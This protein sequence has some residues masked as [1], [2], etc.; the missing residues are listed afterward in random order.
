VRLPFESASMKSRALLALA[1]LTLGTDVASAAPRQRPAPGPLPSSVV[2]FVD[3]DDDDDDGVPDRDQAAAARSSAEVQWLGVE[4]GAKYG[5]RAIRGKGVR[6]LS[7]GGAL[8]EGSPPRDL[9]ARFGLLGVE[10]GAARLELT[11]GTLDA[12][13]YEMMAFDGDGAR[14]DLVASHASLSR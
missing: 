12:R 7:G 6:V 2:L 4:A 13:I 1:A 10:A 8:S 11:T 14:V 5:L 3:A 9:D